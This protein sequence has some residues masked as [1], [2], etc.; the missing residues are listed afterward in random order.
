M[1]HSDL[2]AEMVQVEHLSTQDRLHLARLRRAQQL[3][4]AKQKE[5][6]WLKAQRSR[7]RLGT[8]T[9]SYKR[10]IT[11]EDSVVLLEAAARNDIAEVAKLLQKGVTPD[12][13]NMD[14]L[15]A[16]HQ[17]CIDDNAEMLNLLLDYGANVNAQDSERWTPLHAAAT[18]GHLNLVKILIGRGANLLAVNADGNMPYDICDDEE[19]LDYIEAE[20]SKR[21]V[22]QELIDETRAATET[23]MLHDLQDIAL[24]GGDLEIPDP[25]GATPLHIASANGY[26]R[27][28]EFLLEHH[29]STDAVDNDL[30][31]PVHAAACWGHM[32]VLEM[33][34]QS[35]ADLNAKNK[36]DETPSD[37]CEDP[38]IRERIEQL[39]TEQESKRLAEAQRKRVRRSQSNNTRAQSV[40]RTSLRDKGLTT[41]KDA[42]EEARFRLQAQEGYTT[43]DGVASGAAPANNATGVAATANG[44][45]NNPSSGS[46]SSSK[47]ATSMSSSSSASIN[48]TST[49]T[50]TSSSSNNATTT[51]TTIISNGINSNNNN[52]NN[53][54][55]STPP[56][57]HHHHHHHISNGGTAHLNNINNNSNSSTNGVSNSVRH[58]NNLNNNNN[59]SMM[60]GHHRS[61]KGGNGSPSGG[62]SPTLNQYDRR[63][64]EGKDNDETYLIEG[65]KSRGSSP[66]LAT[67]AGLVSGGGGHHHLHHQHSSIPATNG[68]GGGGQSSS[69]SAASA[70]A[71]STGQGAAGSTATAAA[72]EVYSTSNSENGK[73]NVQVTVL[74]DPSVAGTLADLKK[75]RSQNRSS[76]SPENGSLL[77]GTAPSLTGSLSNG[78]AGNGS[79]T[80][81]TNGTMMG[82]GTSG[83]PVELSLVSNDLHHHHHQLQHHSPHLAH[84]RAG[85]QQ[86]QHYDGSVIGTGTGNGSLHG[87]SSLV[88]TGESEPGTPGGTLSKFSGN[89]SDVVSD[90]TRSRRCCV[91]M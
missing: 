74:V 58:M 2:V 40:R 65:G 24:Q 11:F 18:C 35:G 5:K 59:N 12:A 77:S 78:G 45:N 32:E 17:C 42:V 29:T 91:L 69:L 54:A 48:T 61:G 56:P 20:M 41:K 34:A 70:T 88:T 82:G 75:H 66:L 4:L 44:D 62:G 50:S 84:H 87:G 38:E 83:T 23:Q 19:A 79:M 80:P 67:G 9:S 68:G 43:P 57:P 27:V 60:N 28:V 8:Q 25:Q 81:P 90:S 72:A 33:L 14:G 26:T 73:I 49:S 36:N 15:T 3:K 13:T 37:I 86:Q 31:T 16:L 46:V 10:H 51:T 64:P 89:T 22:T 21:G 55:S 47:H 39:K 6:E 85:Q 52:N 71:A 30:W 7:D 53:A 1:D 76:V 63:S